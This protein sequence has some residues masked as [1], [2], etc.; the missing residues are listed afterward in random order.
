M[1][2]G[3]MSGAYTERYSFLEGV[4][5]MARHG[6]G[7][8]DYNYFI[9]TQT[10]FFTKEEADFKAQIERHADILRAYHIDPSQ[11]HGPWRFPPK[12]RTPEDRA[13]RFAAMTK[14]IRGSAYLGAQYMIIH[15]LMPYGEESP[16]HPE[17]VWEMNLEFMYRLAEYGKEWGITVC[18]ENMPFHRHPIARP[19]EIATFVRTLNHPNFKVCLDTGHALVRGV[20]P[21]EAV[22][23]IG[24]D[25][26]RTLHIHDNDGTSDQHRLV[27]EGLMDFAAFA[28]AL[29]EVSFRGVISI[30]T[31][32]DKKNLLTDEERDA[33]EIEML[34]HIKS[35]FK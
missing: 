15:P 8:I 4:A 16:E 31:L 9:N 2:F 27:G 17:E 26:L 33:R 23:M 7:A 20:Q 22:R 32:V 10:P 24:G 34:A 3:I 30:E 35:F 28:R 21:A 19:D 25:L 13:E 14:S 1:K 12:D 29:D 6:Y 5:K 18:Y 11:T